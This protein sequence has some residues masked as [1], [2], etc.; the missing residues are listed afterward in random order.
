[1]DSLYLLLLLF[2]SSQQLSRIRQVGQTELGPLS[3]QFYRNWGRSTEWIAQVLQLA[4]Q[5]AAA[6]RH[7]REVRFKRPKRQGCDVPCVD[8]PKNTTEH[9]I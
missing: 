4:K 5:W 9:L 7:K 6:F 8:G 1:M 2:F 3:I